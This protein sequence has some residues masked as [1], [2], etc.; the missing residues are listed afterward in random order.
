LVSGTGPVRPIYESVEE[1]FAVGLYDLLERPGLY[2]W[3]SRVLS[4]GRPSVRQ[5]LQRELSL[6]E[7]ALVLD[8]G[9]GTGRH[10]VSVAGQ[11]FGVDF[12]RAYLAYAREHVG[13]PFACMDAARLGFAD[14]SFDAVIAVGLTHHLEDGQVRQVSR[15]I[16][17]VLK[18][19]GRAFIIDAVLPP[20][21]HLSGNLLFR[22]DRGAHPRSAAALGTLIRDAGFAL[23]SANIPGSFPYC[24]AAFEYG[25]ER[26]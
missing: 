14:A 16:A 19:G 5:F 7:D 3:K 26:H 23:R 15:E 6:A 21:W 12:S 24:R 13:R 22:M 8:L 4:L 18:S 20:V 17:R 9:C 1:W 10:A 25:K 2:N 11:Y